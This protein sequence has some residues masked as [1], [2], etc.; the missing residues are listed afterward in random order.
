M[1]ALNT[2]SREGQAAIR[3]AMVI[4][5]GCAI[6]PTICIDNIDMEQRVH[7]L[8][9]GN[10]SKTFRGKWGYIHLPNA[11]FLRSLNP[12]E[13]TLQAYLDSLKKVQS[14]SIEPKHF[15]PNAQG[16][17]TSVEESDCQ[18]PHGASGHPLG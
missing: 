16:G 6:A 2:L 15:M 18:G 8:S 17:N 1:S 4:K 5:D 11:L 7:D 12:D 10:R 14:F 9:V 13:L 3:K